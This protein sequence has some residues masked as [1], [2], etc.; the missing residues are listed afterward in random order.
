LVWQILIDVNI[1]VGNEMFSQLRMSRMKPIV[2]AGPTATGKT[3]LS[4]K[5]AES[6][7][8]FS[9]II[10]CDSRQFYSFVSIGVAMPEK[11]R[12]R[13]FKLENFGTITTPVPQTVAQFVESTKKAMHDAERDASET[14]LVGGS[15]FYVESLFFPPVSEFLAARGGL[16]RLL[17]RSSGSSRANFD[18]EPADSKLG[19]RFKKAVLDAAGEVKGLL[20]QWLSEHCELPVSKRVERNDRKLETEIW[21]MVRWKRTVVSTNSLR[22]ISRR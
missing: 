6:R 1:N 20:E 19:R 15:A 3:G 13:N 17:E 7:D 11:F 4:E 22:L 18:F 16:Q 21:N 12:G 9:K 14:I 5:I 2:I 10:N 8:S